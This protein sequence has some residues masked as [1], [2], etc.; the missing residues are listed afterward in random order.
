MHE[1]RRESSTTGNP[2]TA[3]QKVAIL[4]KIL[5]K[6]RFF[7]SHL[8]PDFMPSVISH[9]KGKGQELGLAEEDKMITSGCLTT[10]RGVIQPSLSP[11]D[12]HDH[13]FSEI[14]VSRFEFIL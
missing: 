1:I 3:T 11:L 10:M 12:S 6:C 13:Q 2:R 7:L 4:H 14:L 8:V 9:R 5:S